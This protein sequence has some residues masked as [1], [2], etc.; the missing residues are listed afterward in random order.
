MADRQRRRSTV[1]AALAALALGALACSGGESRAGERSGPPADEAAPAAQ[2]LRAPA[3]L[4]APDPAVGAAADPRRGSLDA[5]LSR[6]ASRWVARAGELSK[7]RVGAADVQVAVHVRELATGVELASLHAGR[8][9]RPASNMKL[10]TSAA[11]LVLFGPDVEFVTPFEASGPVEG[12]VLRGDL[13]VHAAGD[14]L[15]RPDGDARVEGRLFEVARAIA[16]RGVRRVEGDVVLDEGTFLEPGPGPGWPDPSQ[17]WAEYCARAAGLTVNGGVMRAEVTP[18]APG[19]QA[20]VEVHPAPYGLRPN[21][22]VAS[23]HDSRVDVRVGATLSALTVRGTL[24]ASHATYV[25]EFSHPDP[26]GLFGAVLADALERAGIEVAGELRRRRGVPAGTLLAELR[27]P[28]ADTLLPINR[29]S[30]NGIADQVF[31]AVGNAAGGAGTRE[32]G[33]RAVAAALERLGVPSDGLVQVDGSGLSRDDR[34]SARQVTALLAAVLGGEERVARAFRESLAIAGQAGTLEDRLRGTAAAGR[35][36]AKTGWI[37][38]TSALSGL[39]ERPDGTRLV[40]SVLVAYPAA[41]GGLNQKCFKPMQDE[42]VLLLVE[43]G[44]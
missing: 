42:M 35:V 32:G 1:P 44:G 8:A 39:V 24:P 21:V 5:P 27:S 12:G 20:R 10:V 4:A 36:F 15:C 37:A 40:F 18:R 31:L 17:H 30:R 19:I 29:D 26:V 38:G 7:G 13:V 11:A 25:A 41:E 22:Q 9:Q 2:G 33:A 43:G 23:G 34:V 16:A 6:V 28:L 14:P 3:G